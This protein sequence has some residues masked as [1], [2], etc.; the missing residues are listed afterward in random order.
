L[1]KIKNAIKKIFIMLFKA[2]CNAMLALVFVVAIATLAIPVGFIWLIGGIPKAV[3][4]HRN[5]KRNKK[6]AEELKHAREMEIASLEIAELD[7]IKRHSSSVGVREK[8]MV[9]VA[10]EIIE[11]LGD[12]DQYSI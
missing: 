10:E 8:T 12:T 3:L 6:F 11:N 4:K 9:D 2:F 7:Y 5:A 1:E